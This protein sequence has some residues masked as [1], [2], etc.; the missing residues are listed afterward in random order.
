M[1]LS[2]VIPFHNEE[3][4]IKEVVSSL[5][6]NF[7]K[8]SIDYELILVNNGS[9]DNSPQILEDLAKEKSDKITVVH[10]L[11]N[12]G[13]G[14]GVISGLK[15][16]SSEFIGYM[17][18]DGQIKPED[19]TRV[20][21]SIKNENC[22]LV[23]VKRVVREDG[24]IRKVLS[25]VYNFLFWVAF[26]ARTLDV[27]GSPKIFRRELLAIISPASKD[28]FLDSEIMIKAKYLNLKIREVPIEF[29]RREKGRSEVGLTTIFEFARNMF[30]YKLGKGLKEWKQKTLG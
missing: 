27:N 14:W 20:L 18:G 5:I 19:V 11:V 10:V 4:N 21:N 3:K 12:Q 22:D 7:G 13:Y 2:L 26:N 15:L 30:N 24:I 8:G 28:W 25:T 29:L 17:G 16:A 6:N 1:A 23:K 9:D